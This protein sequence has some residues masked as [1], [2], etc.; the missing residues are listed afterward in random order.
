MATTLLKD[1]RLF[2]GPSS[3]GKGLVDAMSSFGVKNILRY[4]DFYW[5]SAQELYDYFNHSIDEKKVYR[6]V[7]AGEM[8]AL[9]PRIELP[10]TNCLK[11][12]M[13]MFRKDGSVVRRR[14]ICDC[15]SCLDGNFE[16]CEYNDDIEVYENDNDCDHNNDAKEHDEE[17]DEEE[18][19]NHL[20]E[21][22]EPGSVV[23]LYTPNDVKESFYL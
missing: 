18:N 9:P 7:T 14:E 20:L 2:Y 17:K 15:D 13:I 21:V 19:Y 1:I 10:L 4:E 22:I 23:A 12:H 5:S 16:S 6:L 11:Q 8:E 3:H